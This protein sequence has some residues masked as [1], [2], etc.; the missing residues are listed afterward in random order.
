MGF[1]K[2]WEAVIEDHVISL[3]WSI[4]R[5]TL[6]AAAVS[7]PVTVFGADGQVLRKLPG[8][9]FGTTALAWNPNDANLLAS[10]GQDGQVKLWD[11][12]SGATP[13]LL[14]PGGAAWVERVAWSP[15]GD[16]LASGAGRKV[17]LWNRQGQ[18]LREYPDHTS[19]IADLQWRPNGQVLA[20]AAYGA[21][22]LWAPDRAEPLQRF[23]WKGS[24]LTVAWSPE[25]KY[26][27]TGNQDATVHFWNVKTGQDLQMSGYPVKVRELSWDCKSQYLATGG[28]NMVCVWNCSGRGPEGRQP[29]MLEAHQEVVTAV[30]FQ[31]KGPL[32][33]SGGADGLV[34]LWQPGKAEKPLAVGAFDSGVTQ[35]VWSSDDQHFAVGLESGKVAVLAVP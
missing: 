19:T 29:Q 3:A 7:G 25:G 30:A 9:D 4:D 12:K 24:I 34:V 21:L 31:R 5:H 23:T 32:L 8:H 6:A 17:R 22:T 20:S 27:A 26:I 13:A 10:A 28:G 11:D 35:L 18:M 1:R 14:L 33:L 15:R 2:S 16:L